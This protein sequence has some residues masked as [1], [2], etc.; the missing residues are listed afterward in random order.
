MTIQITK[1]VPHIKGEVNLALGLVVVRKAMVD[2]RYK[3]EDNL[4]EFIY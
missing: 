3:R 2:K 4:Y 1:I